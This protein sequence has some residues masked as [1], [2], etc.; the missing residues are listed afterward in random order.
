MKY[1]HCNRGG[2]NS[3]PSGVSLFPAVQYE[4]RLK[5]DLVKFPTK[6]GP[7]AERMHSC[8]QLLGKKQYC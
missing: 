5:E 6:D 4:V 3:L 1:M 7:S 2:E 8:F